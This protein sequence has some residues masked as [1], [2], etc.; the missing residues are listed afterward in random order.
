LEFWRPYF[1]RPYSKR[2]AARSAQC[3]NN[4]R[5]MGTA[6]QSFHAA[7]NVFPAGVVSQLADPNWTYTIGDTNSFPDELGPGWSLFT[8]LLPYSEQQPLYESIR[9][10][11]PII[12]SE[13]DVA[14]RT[15]IA[16]YRCPSDTGERLINVTTCGSPPSASNVPAFMTDAAMC[17]YVGSLGGGN[18]TDP[19]YGTCLPSL[20]MQ[21][22]G[23]R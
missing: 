2:E 21:V 18:G 15:A 16:I 23:T 5:Q 12:A 3:K 20:T 11:L 22:Q 8:L 7:R 17:S 9:L 13:N 10:D 14:R 6:L 1:C 4:L 19:N